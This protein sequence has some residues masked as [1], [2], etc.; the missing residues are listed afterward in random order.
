MAA[1]TQI[2]PDEADNP[3]P[4]FTAKT[5]VKHNEIIVD[6]YLATSSKRD[7]VPCCI[8]FM[9]LYQLSVSEDTGLLFTCI[10]FFSILI[11]VEV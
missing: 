6:I 9:Y 4:P 10:T 3:L 1:F 2:N 7:G 11:Y 8:E 5:M